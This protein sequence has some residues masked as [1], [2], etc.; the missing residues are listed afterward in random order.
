MGAVRP[1]FWWL[2]ERMSGP[3]H[4]CSSLQGSPVSH[5]GP[6]E[7]SGTN[8]GIQ[9]G[10]LMRRALPYPPAK[11]YVPD[12]DTLTGACWGLGCMHLWKEYS[13]TEQRRQDHKTKGKITPPSAKNKTRQSWVMVAHAFN[14]YLGPHACRESASLMEPSS[15]PCHYF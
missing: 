5:E 10:S 7:D 3:L 11:C 14:P 2:P 8:W 9:D 6:C 1:C 15:S 13:I 4:F 12:K